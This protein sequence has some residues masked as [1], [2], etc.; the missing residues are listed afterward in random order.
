MIEERVLL[1]R[2]I[3]SVKPEPGLTDRIYRRRNRKRRNQ[4][5]ATAVVALVLA[6]LA[7]GAVFTAFRHA[8]T[9]RPADSP[10]SWVKEFGTGGH[11]EVLAIA[12]GGS[13]IYVLDQDG[14][15]RGAAL[16]RSDWF[17][18]EFDLNG[19]RTARHRLEVRRRGRPPSAAAALGP[20]CRERDPRAVRGAAA[21]GDR[22]EPG[23]LATAQRGRAPRERATGDE[24]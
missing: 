12:A 7:I 21:R 24:A 15:M 2:A 4:R 3:R 23:R 9:T 20:A 1:E 10:K 8:G 5:I 18:D 6:A 14:F 17:V 11:D 16:L 19:N 13:H 22:R